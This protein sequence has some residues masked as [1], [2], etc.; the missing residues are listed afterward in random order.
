MVSSDRARSL[1]G[2]LGENY[3]PFPS[4]ERGRRGEGWG[5][6]CATVA[7]AREKRERTGRRRRASELARRAMIISGTKSARHA[8][9][10]AR[11]CKVGYARKRAR[12]TRVRIYDGEQSNVARRLVRRFTG[13]RG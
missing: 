11:V 6:L 7:G 2:L 9:C 12:G 4:G 13:A 3:S 10:A 5:D 1:A 8:L